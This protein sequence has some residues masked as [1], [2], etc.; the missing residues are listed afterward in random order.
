MTSVKCLRQLMP[1]YVLRRPFRTIPDARYFYA[2]V[3]IE[4]DKL[5]NRQRRESRHKVPFAIDD[6]ISYKRV[7]IS[8]SW[9]QRPRLSVHNRSA[10]SWIS[11]TAQVVIKRL[12]VLA[13]LLR[14]F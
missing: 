7:K 13:P 3:W 5:A 4:K 14:F 6:R 12:I 8:R 11:Q 2:I 9:N 1:I 10:N